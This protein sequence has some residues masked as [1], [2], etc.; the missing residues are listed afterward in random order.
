MWILS[1]NKNLWLKYRSPGFYCMEEMWSKQIALLSS[2]LTVHK[3][4]YVLCTIL[5]H[6]CWETNSM[7]GH[8]RYFSHAMPKVNVA[9]SSVT[10]FRF[11]S[12]SHLWH[13]NPCQW[14]NQLLLDYTMIKVNTVFLL[15][16]TM[17]QNAYL[18]IRA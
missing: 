11:R 8:V 2:A 12:E 1:D 13:N 5:N 10:P 17:L 18:I 15:P 7:H 14:Q 3:E 9:K 16:L 4:Q 6:Y